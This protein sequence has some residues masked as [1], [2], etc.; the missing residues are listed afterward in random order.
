MRKLLYDPYLGIRGSV[1]REFTNRQTGARLG[2][3]GNTFVRASATSSDVELK[4]RLL[5]CSTS[6]VLV[7]EFHHS[8]PDTEKSA[9]RFGIIFLQRGYL[10]LMDGT[11]QL[12][13]AHLED[14]RLKIWYYFVSILGEIRG[15]N[16]V[17]VPSNDN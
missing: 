2:T 7:H 13:I 10:H 16:L 4:L 15:K 9:S 6:S 17:R 8:D 14:V 5:D 12:F 3:V 1:D 11:V